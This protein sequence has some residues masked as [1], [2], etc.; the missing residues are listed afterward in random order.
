MEAQTQS[1]PTE[2]S[3]AYATLLAR[4]G[5]EIRQGRAWDLLLSQRFCW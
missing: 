4:M 1:I 3:A 2:P 5:T